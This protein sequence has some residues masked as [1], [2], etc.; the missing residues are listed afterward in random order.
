M[1]AAAGEQSAEVGKSRDSADTT[2]Q[3]EVY[4]ARHRGVDVYLLDSGRTRS[5]R[6]IYTYTAEEE[7]EDPRRR[8]GTGHWDAHYLNLILQRGVLELAR[9]AGPP[10]VF[11]CH[12]GHSAFLPAI[13]RECS[14]YREELGFTPVLLNQFR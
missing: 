3:I 5:K 14:P 1:P 4:R 9:I 6:A 8:K 2:E 12:D 10:D 7:R 11:H 13:L